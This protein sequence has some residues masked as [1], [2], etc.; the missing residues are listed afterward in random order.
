V[1][2]VPQFGEPGDDRKRHV[3]GLHV[4][5]QV[6]GLEVPKFRQPSAAEVVEP[7]LH[8]R[9]P[10]QLAEVGDPLDRR[11]RE[12]RVGGQVEFD[13]VGKRPG[14]RLH[15]GVA[16]HR[17]GETERL[18]SGAGRQ[19]SDHR[20]VERPAV[21]NLQPAQVRERRERRHV[22][23]GHGGAVLDG[24]AG[25][26]AGVVEGALR[27]RSEGFE[28]APHRI[29]VLRWAGGRGPDEADGEDESA[30]PRPTVS[31]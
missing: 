11:R 16:E 2:E 25:Q 14:D 12:V 31:R 30:R 20:V 1:L 5:A 18:Q 22:G 15:G 4:A 21:E 19:F 23:R 29:D 26:A 6:E 24:D 28:P 10:A 13:E 8:Q 27:G 9:Q 17:V 7:G 3:A